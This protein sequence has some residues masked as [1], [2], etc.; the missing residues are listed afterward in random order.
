MILVIF[1]ALFGCLTLTAARWN[2]DPTAKY[3][4]YM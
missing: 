1:V 4:R 3:D 2:Y